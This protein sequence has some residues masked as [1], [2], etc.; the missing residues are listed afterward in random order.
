M[1]PKVRYA[2]QFQIVSHVNRL[3]GALV[4]S[5]ASDNTARLQNTNAAETRMFTMNA[6]QHKVR[7]TAQH[8]QAQLKGQHAHAPHTVVA[9]PT[10]PP[11]TQPMTTPLAREHD[12][13]IAFRVVHA[14]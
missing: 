8:H 5:I 10:P 11:P 2:L 9:A 14:L 13:G 7:G 3:A 6:L 12:Y 1:A 4:S